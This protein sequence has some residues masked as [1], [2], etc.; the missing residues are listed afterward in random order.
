MTLRYPGG[1]HKQLQELAQRDHRSVNGEIVWL[2]LVSIEWRNA[3]QRAREHF[4]DMGPEEGII[5]D[6]EMH[7]AQ[8]GA[9]PEDHPQPK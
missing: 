7:G 8:A 4:E 3:W 2:L 6:I 5:S 9:R 1:L